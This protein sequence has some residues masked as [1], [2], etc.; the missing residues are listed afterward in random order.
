M[1]MGRRDSWLV[2]TSK[3]LGCA[4]LNLEIKASIETTSSEFDCS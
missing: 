1:G 2:C 4:S 3:A